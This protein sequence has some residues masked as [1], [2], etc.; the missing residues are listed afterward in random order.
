MQ[1]YVPTVAY[2]RAHAITDQTRVSTHT[3]TDEG[4]QKPC[5]QRPINL[6]THTRPYTDH[7]C[8]QTHIVADEC[9]H[10][11]SA[12]HTH[13]H[14]RT[15]C[16]CVQKLVQP[17]WQMIVH[18]HAHSHMYTHADT[19]IWAPESRL[20][21]SKC[22]GRLLVA[23]AHTHMH[24]DTHAHRHKDRHT[25]THTHTQGSREYSTP[26]CSL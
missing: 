20:L 23:G 5:A 25:D 8:A 18:M 1:T 24:K 13:T 22:E 21:C 7:T 17:P 11:H 4:N 15:Q 26:V 19:L 3:Q 9:S 14:S 10:T 16:V 12:T 6:H 2:E